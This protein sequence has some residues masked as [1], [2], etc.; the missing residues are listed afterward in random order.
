MGRLEAELKAVRARAEAMEKSLRALD[1]YMHPDR[2]HDKAEALEQAYAQAEEMLWPDRIH[3]EGEAQSQGLALDAEARAQA[4]RHQAWTESINSQ[5]DPALRRELEKQRDQDML[6]VVTRSRNVTADTAKFLREVINKAAHPSEVNSMRLDHTDADLAAKAAS[7]RD[8][9]SM[10]PVPFLEVKSGGLLHLDGKKR[11]P[12]V[13]ESYYEIPGLENAVV[14]ERR[15][16]SDGELISQTV[17]TSPD[18]LR[19]RGDVVT[20][21]PRSIDAVVDTTRDMDAPQLADRS[22]WRDRVSGFR[23]SN[24]FDG[25]QGVYARNG[26]TREQRR[27]RPKRRGGFWYNLTR[28]R[29]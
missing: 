28:G 17:I 25:P 27:T 11:G 13:L 20:L 22:G 9:L 26:A 4:E 12:K 14:L 19:H 5:T 10:E 18:G 8:A 7:R 6:D 1:D 16:R 24:V 3:D 23:T 15:K 21:P 2:V 29:I